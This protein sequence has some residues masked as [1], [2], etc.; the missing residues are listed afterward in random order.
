[1]P[2]QSAFTFRVRT[3]G[4]VSFREGILSDDCIEYCIL[5]QW[6]ALLSVI[7]CMVMRSLYSNGIVVVHAG[8]CLIGVE[9]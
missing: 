4:S 5:S 2:S 9:P 7:D 1:M 3:F 6:I 8:C